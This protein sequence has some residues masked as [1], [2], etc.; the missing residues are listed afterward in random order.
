ME[1]ILIAIFER[2]DQSVLSAVMFKGNLYAT[3][4]T[5]ANWRQ[6]NCATAL[7]DLIKSLEALTEEDGIV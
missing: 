3:V 2:R 4:D 6:S 1:R 7:H 5:L